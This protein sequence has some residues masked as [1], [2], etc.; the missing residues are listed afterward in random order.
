[1]FQADQLAYSRKMKHMATHLELSQP[2]LT[3][4]CLLFAEC[5][6]DQCSVLCL[7]RL[8]SETVFVE[9]V[10]ILLGILRGTRTQTLPTSV[11]PNVIYPDPN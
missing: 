10:E 6:V 11:W 8:E 2:L 5:H 9:I 4:I 1:M 3:V 7:D